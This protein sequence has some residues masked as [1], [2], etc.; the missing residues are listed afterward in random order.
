MSMCAKVP[1]KQPLA[2]SSVWAPPY[3][4]VHLALILYLTYAHCACGVLLRNGMQVTRGNH[5]FAD[6]RN[7]LNILQQDSSIHIW[8]QHFKTVP[9]C[10]SKSLEELTTGKWYIN[11][12]GRYLYEPDTCVLHRITGE[13]ARRYG[14]TSVECSQLQSQMY[15]TH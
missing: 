3:T 15:L 14:F 8:E 10:N 11:R 13:S 5:S 1:S 12:K 6:S 7:Y 2:T 9:P 4:K